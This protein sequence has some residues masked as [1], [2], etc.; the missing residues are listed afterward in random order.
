MLTH[1]KKQMGSSGKPCNVPLLRVL[2]GRC[3]FK[4]K[5]TKLIENKTGC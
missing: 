3:K 5:K 4:A 2:F 1:N